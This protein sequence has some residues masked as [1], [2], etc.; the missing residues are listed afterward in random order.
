VLIALVHAVETAKFIAAWTDY[1]AAVRTLAMGAASDP[2]LGDPGF[3]S[4]ARIGPS[5]NRL[6]WTST[7]PYLSTL[8]APR[9]APARLV[10]DP[11]ASYFWLSCRDAKANEAAERAVPVASRRLVRTLECLHR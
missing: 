9:L 2:A 7:T 1:K 4:S 3:V 8:L 6:S 5:L 11:D 10:V